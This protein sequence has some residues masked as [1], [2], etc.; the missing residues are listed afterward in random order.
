MLKLVFN[1]IKLEEKQLISY[2]KKE[3]VILQV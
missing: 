1:W 3:Q 2:F